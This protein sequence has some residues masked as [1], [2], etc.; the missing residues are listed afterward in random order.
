MPT[1]AALQWRARHTAVLQLHH[2]ARLDAIGQTGARARVQRLHW[3]RRAQAC[4][5]LRC[6]C[7]GPWHTCR[8]Q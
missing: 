1:L 5:E 8:G 6:Q 2:P 4:S 3:R 7:S